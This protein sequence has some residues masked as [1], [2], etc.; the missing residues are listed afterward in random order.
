MTYEVVGTKAQ[1]E[2]DSL[3]DASII[4]H[5]NIDAV[6]CEPY[7]GPPQRRSISE[8]DAEKLL[9]DVKKLYISL[10]EV[11]KKLSKPGFRV[12]MVLPSYR[13]ISGW[14]SISLKDIVDS[15]WELENRKHGRDLK[16]ERNNSIIIRNIFILTK[17]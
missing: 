1:V 10:F 5:T 8:K 2:Y 4:K 14:K 3:M 12:V 16:W 7:M 6:I 9:K 17:K 13:T 15:R 11:L